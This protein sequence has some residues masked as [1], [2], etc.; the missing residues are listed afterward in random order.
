[1]N[2]PIFGKSKKST[3]F[4]G[5]K[6]AMIFAAG[7]GTRLKPI[8]D[9][10]PKAMVPVGGKPL[11]WHIV[12]KLKRSGFERIV[13]NV[14]HFADQIIDYV[15]ANNNFGMDILISDERDLLLDTGGG[16]RKALPLFDEGSPVL[17]HNVDIFSNVD[18]AA[19]YDKASSADALL[20]V[21]HLRTGR[22]LLFDSDMSLSGWTNDDRGIVKCVPGKEPAALSRYAFSG[23]HIV[24]PYLLE[25]MT[26]MPERFG[27]FEYY[28]QFC[29]QYRFLGYEQ[30]DLQMLDVGKLDT[31]TQAEEFLKTAGTV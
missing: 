6:Q 8:T 15:K 23:I 5:M 3:T 4:A 24:H 19:F 16:L 1:M 27:I 18:L 2:V 26:Q 7:L 30:H 12:M 31:L 14:H 20:L 17:I 28:M 10:M 9:S 22:D 25:S 11:L 21:Y 13:I 29:Q